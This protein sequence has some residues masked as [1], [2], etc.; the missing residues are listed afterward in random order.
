M[1]K[2]PW[3][4]SLQGVLDSCPYEF[5]SW[6]NPTLEL[7][8]SSP[9][10]C[11]ACHG[12]KGLVLRVEKETPLR[13]LFVPQ[14]PR[15]SRRV[16]GIRPAKLLWYENPVDS[17]F[18]QITQ[19]LKVDWADSLLKV[20]IKGVN[21]EWKRGQ[22][23]P[24]KTID[25]NQLKVVMSKTEK[26]RRLTFYFNRFSNNI[27]VVEWPSTLVRLDL[28]GFRGCI[29]GA[30]WPCALKELYL[31]S[32]SGALSGAEF[33]DSL[34]VVSLNGFS[35]E[36]PLVGVKWNS[37]KILFLVYFDKYMDEREG[38]NIEWPPGLEELNLQKFNQPI[39]HVKW[40]NTL[41]VLYFGDWWNES[42]VDVKF[43]D[44]L[45][46]LQLGMNFRGSLVGVTWPRSLK[47]LYLGAF[48]SSLD[49]IVWPDSLVELHMGD[50][51]QSIDG[52]Q[53]PK[54]L[55]RLWYDNDEYQ[56]VDG[57]LGSRVER[58]KKNA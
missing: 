15:I 2:P 37:V 17:E 5:L 39:D 50:F 6:A 25:F 57:K 44:S 45:E 58:K 31:Y 34:E 29:L 41:K 40:P 12:V 38:L 4:P 56:A 43:P 30:K 26:L 3:E 7:R 46:D 53:W 49:G 52:V 42:I 1:A 9:R 21:R 35:E 23:R 8:I 13:I 36:L 18:Q 33:P 28:S 16:R 20:E 48:N 19:L 27:S 11:R 54:S 32:W 14:G 55:T 22:A 51:S 10:I 24:E 47:K